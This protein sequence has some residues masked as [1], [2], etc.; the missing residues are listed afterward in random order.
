MEI[1]T[2]KLEAGRYAVLVDGRETRLI[3]QRGD[4]P[5][6]R[7]QQEWAIGVLVPSETYPRWLCG[8]QR[9]LQGSVETLHAIM[10][11]IQ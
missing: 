9:S 5:K 4:A 2:K 8:D 1:S 6:Y 11:E 10:S 7:Q 3:I